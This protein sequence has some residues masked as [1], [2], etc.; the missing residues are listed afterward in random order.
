[1]KKYSQENKG[2]KLRKAVSSEGEKY[3][4]EEQRQQQSKFHVE[5][6]I[7]QDDKSMNTNVRSVNC[8]SNSPVLP[9]WS[10]VDNKAAA[11][12]A[13]IEEQQTTQ[14]STT[15]TLQDLS[16]SSLSRNPEAKVL[17]IAD[18]R[19]GREARAGEALRLK[20]EQLRILQEQ[21]TML[22]ASLDKVEEEVAHVQRDRLAMDD[23][24]QI[25]QEKLVESQTQERSIKFSLERII[26]DNTEKDKQLHIM[27][28]QNAELLRLLEVEEEIAGK[29]S[30]EKE[31]AISDLEGL[32][33]EYRNIMSAAKE[34]EEL[35]GK[36]SVEVQLLSKEVGEGNW[37]LFY[38]CN[39]YPS[40]TSFFC[41]ATTCHYY[42]LC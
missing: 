8:R 26:M 7:P 27:T 9:S 11:A 14:E 29:L 39:K 2:A 30:T 20:D 16:S 36:S 41:Y 15:N 35:A 38:L 42:Y 33:V 10:S 6:E 21:N 17:S 32:K 40:T 24:K 18:I 31:V 34:K 37:C 13:T 12:Q 3:H 28:S 19:T 25:L 5:R 22:L 23:A 1:M 4:M